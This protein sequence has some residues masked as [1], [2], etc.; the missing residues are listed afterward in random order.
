MNSSE[1]LTLYVEDNPLERAEKML[2]FAGILDDGKMAS[3]L[4]KI[5]PKYQL[6][7]NDQGKKDAAEEFKKNI[8]IL[9]F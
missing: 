9:K 1:H 3:R 2:K 8:N 5:I 7:D 4:A 6:L